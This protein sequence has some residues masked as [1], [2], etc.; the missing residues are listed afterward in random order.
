MANAFTSTPSPEMMVEN[1][2]AFGNGDANGRPPMTPGAGGMN[3]PNMAPRSAVVQGYSAPGMNPPGMATASSH[4]GPMQT[5]YPMPVN[6]LADGVAQMLGVLKDSVYPSQREYAAECLSNVD[7]RTN[8]QV[9]DSLLT[10]ARQDPAASVR[11]GC[12]RCLA[13]MNLDSTA[14]MNTLQALK[15]DTDP[16]VR[17]EVEA[18]LQ[19]K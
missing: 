7:W 5:G 18:A 12:V 4:S 3:L 17:Q 15:M 14:M 6:L 9:A 2:N 10:A 19:K 1:T 11:A 13:K 8:P 16:R